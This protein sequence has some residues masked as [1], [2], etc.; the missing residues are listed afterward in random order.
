MGYRHSNWRYNGAPPNGIE[1]RLTDFHL[2]C[3]CRFGCSM[4]VLANGANGI[5][6]AWPASTF[7]MTPRVLASNQRQHRGA[8]FE[9]ALQ[10]NSKDTKHQLMLKNGRPMMGASPLEIRYAGNESLLV[11]RR[12]TELEGGCLAA[13]A[14][15]ALPIE[16]SGGHR[17]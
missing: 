15:G 11:L 10:V 13:M 6:G 5:T 7:R 4:R 17:H 9:C 12:T 1:Q 2:L 8:R 16:Q 3:V 14:D